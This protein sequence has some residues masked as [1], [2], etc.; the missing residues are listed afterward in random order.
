MNCNEHLQELLNQ[1]TIIR[2]Y[3]NISLVMTDQ[4]INKLR[5]LMIPY[6]PSPI[7]FP[8]FRPIPR[9]YRQDEGNPITRNSRQKRA[10]SSS[11][12]PPKKRKK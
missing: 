5:N 9:Q 3:Q 11:G 1:L 6:P 4:M 7:P 10:H 12:L 2:N 8:P